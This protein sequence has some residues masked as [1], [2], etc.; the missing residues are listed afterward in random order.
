MSILAQ[1]LT[2]AV[3]K[4]IHISF[5]KKAQPITHILMIRTFHFIISFHL[6]MQRPVALSNVATIFVLFK[7]TGI[8]YDRNTFISVGEEST[9]FESIVEFTNPFHYASL[10]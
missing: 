1:G 6:Q 7:Q 5:K 2:V 8:A 10:C 9:G 4:H 3:K